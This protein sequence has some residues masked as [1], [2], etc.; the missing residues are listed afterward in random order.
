MSPSS[1][2]T[3]ICEDRDFFHW[4]QGCPWCAVWVLRVDNPEVS[5]RVL[6]A[7]GLLG[8]ALLNRYERQ[9]HVTLAYRGLMDAAV[10]HPAAQFT[11]EQL[12]QDVAALRA[13]R[14]AP[15]A[16]QVQGAGSFS[17]VPYLSVQEPTGTLTRLHAALSQDEQLYPGWS[18]VPHVTVGHY[19]RE[20]PVAQA[21]QVMEQVPEVALPLHIPVDAVWLARYRTEDIAGP[22]FWEGV[23][24]CGTG[25]YTPQPGALWADA[26]L[27]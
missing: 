8:A 13:L 2:R 21:L 11:P 10:R 17:T 1:E 20:L 25:I 7:R 5:R 19:A 14:G 6:A 22:L 9:A 27:L 23:V 24:D 4:H 12:G 15:F 18:Y 26:G 3:L 16:V